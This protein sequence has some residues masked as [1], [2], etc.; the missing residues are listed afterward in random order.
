MTTSVIDNAGDSIFSVDKPTDYFALLG[1]QVGLLPSSSYTGNCWK[2]IDGEYVVKYTNT[3]EA[4]VDTIGKMLDNSL[5]Q[6]RMHYAK[7]NP[8]ELQTNNKICLYTDGTYKVNSV[9][10]YYLKNPAKIDIKATPFVEYTDMPKHTH[11][12]FVKVAA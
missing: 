12:E 4:S 5:S 6:H 7:C 11:I 8:L 3:L 2:K 10:L 9:T 1:T